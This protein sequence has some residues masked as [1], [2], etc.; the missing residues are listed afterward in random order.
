MPS[1]CGKSF[2][3]KRTKVFIDDG[4]K[5]VK[6]YKNYFDVVILDLTDPSGP[7][8]FLYSVNFYKDIYAALKNDGLLLTQSGVYPSMLEGLGMVRKN[9]KAVFPFMKTHL[10]LV[11]SFGVGLNSYTLGSKKSLDMNLKTVQERFSQLKINTKY[12]TPEI[13]LASA[14]LSK[15]IK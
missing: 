3:D 8:K 11:P 15:D 10:G 2:E 4:L 5:F 12:Y 7:S 1:L 13:H 9:L 14:V 6:N